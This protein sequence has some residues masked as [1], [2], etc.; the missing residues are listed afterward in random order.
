[1]KIVLILAVILGSWIGLNVYNDQE[2]FSN[3][4]ATKQDRERLVNAAKEHATAAGEV[5][6][7]TGGQ[8][9]DK[10]GEIADG[11]MNESHQAL[12]EVKE[13]S[14]QKYGEV[15]EKVKSMNDK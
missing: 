5:I 8:I 7:E 12:Q 11:A 9:V 2:L 6:Q 3:P 1:M 4:I 13:K 14:M 15:R 10:S